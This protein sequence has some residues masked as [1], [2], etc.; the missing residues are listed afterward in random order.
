MQTHPT[1]TDTATMSPDARRFP[2]TT[3]SGSPCIPAVVSHAS[4]GS[5]DARH[6]QGAGVGIRPDH[7]PMVA[8]SNDLGR[9]WHGREVGRSLAQSGPCIPQPTPSPC[10]R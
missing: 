10:R 8:C 4:A 1:L 5:A 3:C 2:G 6:P 9:L 7:G